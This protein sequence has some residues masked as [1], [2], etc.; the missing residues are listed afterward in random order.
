MVAER[1]TI[2]FGVIGTENSHVNQACKSF[3]IERSIKGA[4]V[5][6]LYPGE[7]DT[8]EHAR[9]VQEE[10]KV[11]LLVEK[12][13]DMLG[14]VDAVII[15]NRHAKYHCRYARLFLENKIPTF[16]DKPFSCDL[17]EAKGV[18]ELSR[19][20]DTWLSSS[21]LVWKTSSFQGFFKQAEEELGSIHSGMVGGPFDFESE[22]GGAF[23]YGIHSVEMLLNGFGYD[24]KT[25]H[26]RL[27]GKNC[28]VTTTS[29]SGKLVAIHL[30]GEGGGSFQVLVNGEKG[31]RYL[32][33]DMSDAYDAGFRS[34]IEDI[35]TNMKSLTDEQLLMP[36]KVLLAIDKSAKTGQ[37]IEIV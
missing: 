26:A 11:P 23:F 20:T 32:T 19:K 30:I 7:G 34:L 1:E 16:I 15:M 24:V 6:V 21:S 28:W 13:E 22:F 17:D 3:N 4:V 2:R 9:K 29:E 33:V 36:I 25:V 5:R 14:E 10:G 37:E 35:R 8:P 12:P 27:H 31:S 18:I